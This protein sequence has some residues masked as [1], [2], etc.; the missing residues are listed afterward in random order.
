M[1]TANI[2]VRPSANAIETA[3]TSPGDPLQ[4]G[5]HHVRL[6]LRVDGEWLIG[7]WDGEGWYDDAEFPV[8]PTHWACM[9][10]EPR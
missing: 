9:P 4:D 6:L 2:I 7:R 3:P 10:A 5:P 8:T 1:T